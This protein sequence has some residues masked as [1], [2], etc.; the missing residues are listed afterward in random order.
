MDGIFSFAYCGFILKDK[1]NNKILKKIKYIFIVQC[2]E[3][4]Y[5]DNGLDNNKLLKG[6]RRTKTLQ[7]D[8]GRYLAKLWSA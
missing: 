7:A 8:R 6:I 1:R 2:I 5:C 3:K 4:I